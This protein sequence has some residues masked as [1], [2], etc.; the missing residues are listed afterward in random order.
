MSAGP[1]PRGSSRLVPVGPGID[2]TNLRIVV[3]EPPSIEGVVIHADTG[4]PVANYYLEAE[5]GD[6]SSFDA[7]T[8]AKGRF[9]IHADELSQRHIRFLPLGF[10]S[11]DPQ[12]FLEG[13]TK[14]FPM[15]SLDVVLR[16][17][18]WPEFR[19]R[20]RHSDGS[21]AMDFALL[22]RRGAVLP[23]VG[24]P[25]VNGVARFRGVLPGL[26]KIRATT[27]PPR[28]ATSSW[29]DCDPS[30]HLDS[31]FDIELADTV[32][33]KVRIHVPDTIKIRP[34]ATLRAK[35][36]WL[37]TG[38]ANP[39]GTLTLATPE[40]IEGLTLL[41]YAGGAR[42]KVRLTAAHE[43]A[44][45]IEVELVDPR[46]TNPARLTIKIIGAAAPIDG[47]A[48]RRY[49]GVRRPGGKVVSR[50][51]GSGGINLAAGDWEVVVHVDRRAWTPLRSSS[52]GK[53][54]TRVLTTV[55]LKPNE[56]RKIEVALPELEPGSVRGIARYRGEPLRNRVVQFRS[57]DGPW[58]RIT[59]TDAHGR[60]ERLLMPKGEYLASVVNFPVPDITTD[61]LLWYPGKI[62]IGRGV[63]LQ[64]NLDTDRSVLAARVLSPDGT[65]ATRT[66]FS[67]IGYGTARTDSRGEVELHALPPGE[68]TISTIP[69]LGEKKRTAK[70]PRGN[71]SGKGPVVVRLK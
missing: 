53:W 17:R 9:R 31:P 65:P 57:V 69:G 56:K 42:R 5:G 33:L 28:S 55:H 66:W 58:V 10:D 13:P 64:L 22:S 51:S 68:I 21:A 6:R 54:K 15:S 1:Q 43:R 7:R 63:N 36:G 20:A 18:P 50:A 37:A 49:V 52:P 25:P 23:R 4:K 38:K 2:A 67:I 12:P 35:D 3:N 59:R 8:D 19:V 60:F 45:S 24:P 47:I 30:H 34:A 32:E 62:S 71:T 16:V 48:R 39:D 29:V 61:R 46:P 70:L 26:V 44:R 27:K 41:S 40:K 14:W 11:E